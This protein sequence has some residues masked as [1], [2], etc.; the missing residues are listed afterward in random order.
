VVGHFHIYWKAVFGVRASIIPR[1]VMNIF[2]IRSLIGE[3][4]FFAFKYSVRNETS[5]ISQRLPVKSYAQFF[6]KR[7]NQYARIKAR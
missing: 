4:L 7:E 5:E 2:N 1:V 3:D 6:E